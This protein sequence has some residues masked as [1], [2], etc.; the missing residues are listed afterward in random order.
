MEELYYYRVFFEDC[1]K[2]KSGYIDK[3][4]FKTLLTKLRIPKEKSEKAVS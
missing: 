3:I 2:D 4:E 1:D